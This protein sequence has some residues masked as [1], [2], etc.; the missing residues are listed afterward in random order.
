MGEP[1]EYRSTNP[2]FGPWGPMHLS[3]FGKPGLKS[4][5]YAV[6]SVIAAHVNSETSKCHIT[7]EQIGD[8]LNIKK[9]DTISAS[10]ERLTGAG[11]LRY[12]KGGWKK[13]GKC[14]C[15][16]YTILPPRIDTGEESI[17]PENGGLTEG[18]N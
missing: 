11:L 6:Y 15:N 5:D 10:L 17:P 8:A 4:T 13:A 16:E 12:V 7:H 14:A 2:A 9:D 18:E 1:K 3:V